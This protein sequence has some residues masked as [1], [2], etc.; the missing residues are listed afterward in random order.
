MA[1][2]APNVVP[3]EGNTLPRQRAALDPDARAAKAERERLRKAKRKLQ[4]QLDDAKTQEELDAA[5]AAL[6]GVKVEPRTVEVK[7]GELHKDELKPEWP[8]DAQLES[9]KVQLRGWVDTAVEMTAPLPAP[10]AI[11]K[12]EGDRLVTGLAPFAALNT[13]K[14]T[15]KALAITTVLA[16]LGPK[17]A[18]IAAPFVAWGVRKL[19]AKVSGSTEPVPGPFEQPASAAI[20]E[21]APK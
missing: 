6:R 16:V 9:A 12:E 8:T 1:E 15:P 7:P 18:I 5:V 17:V 13:E 10:L 11:T 4:S 3:I 20:V 19:W 2:T 21:A 14:L